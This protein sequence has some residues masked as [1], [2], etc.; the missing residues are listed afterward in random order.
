MKKVVIFVLLALSVPSLCFA[1]QGWKIGVH[2]AYS[3]GG[4]IEES[5]AGFGGQAEVAINDSFSVEL[6]VS[7]FSDGISEETVEIDQDITTIGM[8]AIWKNK[9]SDKLMLYL[10]G[11]LDY[12]IIDMDVKT[13]LSGV[14]FEADVDDKVGFHMGCGLQFGMLRNMGMFVEYRYTFLELDAELKGSSSWRSV[15]DEVTGDYNFGLIKAGINF[16]F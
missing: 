11:G 15:S 1:Q 9:T 5:E 7:R 3:A 8:S 14:N 6:A 2:G 10:L 12:N 4:D 13:S 16:S